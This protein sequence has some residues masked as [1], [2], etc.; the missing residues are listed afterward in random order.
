MMIAMNPVTGAARVLFIADDPVA[1]KPYAEAL[2]AGGCDVYQAATYVAALPNL[3][4]VDIIVL[5]ELA[6]FAYPGQ[7]A[8]VLRVPSDMSPEDTVSEVRHRV[9]LRATRRATVAV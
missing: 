7:N 9:G 1:A 5:L 3:P 8:L 6:M 2:K 4:D